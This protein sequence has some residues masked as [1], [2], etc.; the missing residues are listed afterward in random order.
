MKEIGVE[1][2]A[3]LI[4]ELNCTDLIQILAQEKFGGMFTR[5]PTFK[6]LFNVQSVV[7]EENLCT[8]TVDCK[9]SCSS[10][11]HNSERCMYYKFVGDKIVEIGHL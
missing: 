7:R 11:N 9:F 10:T 8:V 1:R 5:M 6:G 2:F 4:L 3:E